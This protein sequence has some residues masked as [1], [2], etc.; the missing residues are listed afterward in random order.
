MKSYLIDHGKTGLDNK[1]TKLATYWSTPL[2]QLCV[3]MKV[4]NSVRFIPISYTANSLYDVIASGKF[5]STNIPHQTWRSLYSD[6]SLQTN[7]RRQGFNVAAENKGF[8]RVRI[9]IIGNNERDCHTADSFIG[10]GATDSKERKICVTQS[11]NSC[12]NTACADADKGDR[13][14][15]AMGYIFVR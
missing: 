4:S 1:E 5:H 11:T 13:E 2:K 7:C 6:S 3:G 8:A 14:V 10:F 9:G 15:K 12:G